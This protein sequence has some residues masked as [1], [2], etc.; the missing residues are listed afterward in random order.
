MMRVIQWP[1]LALFVKRDK[2]SLVKIYHQGRDYMISR[3]DAAK[4]IRGVRNSL[5][6]IA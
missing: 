3:D 6:Q 2:T 4:I 5:K 1:G